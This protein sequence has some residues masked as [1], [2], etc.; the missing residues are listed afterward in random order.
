MK[1]YLWVGLIEEENLELSPTG[2]K[3]LERTYSAL[4]SSDFVKKEND[5]LVCLR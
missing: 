1:L 4:L 5:I 3:P 2:T